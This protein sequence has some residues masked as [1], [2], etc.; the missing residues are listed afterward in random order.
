MKS[1]IYSTDSHEHK[2][3]TGEECF[4]NDC[5]NCYQDEHVPDSDWLPLDFPEYDED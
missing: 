3:I 1:F 5:S 4:C 2:M